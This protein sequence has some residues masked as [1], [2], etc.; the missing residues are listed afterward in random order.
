MIW[1]AM[2][3]MLMAMWVGHLTDIH[4]T[5]LLGKLEEDEEIFMEVPQGFK[6]HYPG[7]VV[8]RML[9]AIYGL[10]QVAMAFW[11]EL[12]KCMRSMEMTQSTAD[13][14]LY[15]KWTSDGLAMILSWIDDNLIIGLETAVLKVKKDLMS[16]FECDGCGEMLKYIG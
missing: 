6:K 3:L 13:P 9:R 5:F 1:I 4:G 14:C 11:Q 2:T 12:I 16:R 15:F 7:N 10:K 8:L